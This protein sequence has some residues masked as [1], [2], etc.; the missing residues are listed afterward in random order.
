M[1]RLAVL[2]VAAVTASVVVAVLA[3]SGSANH[4]G[5]RTLVFVERADQGTF[6]FID[7]P[8]RTRLR[9]GFPERISTG[10]MVIFTNPEYDQ[11]NT[12]RVGT[13]YARCIV[14]FG[15]RTFERSRFL[16]TGIVK[17]F[18][19][20]AVVEATFR[21]SE[22]PIVGAVTGGTGAYEGASGSFTS[23][24]QGRTTRITVHLVR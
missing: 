23:D 1:K 18:D 13:F 6:K 4:P 17:L 9:R 7:N 15:R 20:T 5:S 11:S 10:D 14:V 2:A 16:C 8:P 21:G 3:S 24:E 22:D 19:G 12:R